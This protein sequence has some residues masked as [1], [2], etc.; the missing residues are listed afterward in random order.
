MTAFDPNSAADGGLFGLPCTEQDSALVVVP[1]P[2]EATTSYGGGTSKGPSAIFEAS[3]QIDL[4]DAEVHKPYEPGIFM[5]PESK[6]VAGWNKLAK[7]AAQKI[8]KNGG[9]AD[10]AE[11]KKALKTAN[12]LGGKLNDWVYGETSE[13]MKAGKI[14]GVVGGDHS[15][16]LG[17]FKAATENY[18][19]FGLLHFDAHIDMRDAYEGFTF[20]HASIMRN[21]MGAL[22]KIRKIV[23]V[24]IRDFCEQEDEYIRGLGHRADVFHQASLERRRFLGEPWDRVATEIVNS[25]PKQVWITFDI[26]GLDPR[27]CPGTGTP[28]PG[29]LDLAEAN[30]IFSILARSGRKILGFDLVEVAPSNGSEWDANVAMRLLYKMAAWTFVS[31]GL[32]HPRI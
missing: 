18:G 25:L 21:A 29:G 8:I 3:A 30:R 24:G 5:R 15:V 17:A 6:E 26:D 9:K 13:L 12:E 22:P 27:Y 32:C 23:Q 4:F 16:P 19:E 2:W 1:V 11:L 20:S 7:A 10:K 14:V 28:V 31:R